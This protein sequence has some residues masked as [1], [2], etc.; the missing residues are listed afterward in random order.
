MPTPDA[1]TRREVLLTPDE[2]HGMMS[3]DPAP[4][5]LAVQSVNPC[6]GQ[7]SR[8]G[9]WIPG[10]VDAEAYTD[11]AA[12]GAPELGQRPLPEITKLQAAARR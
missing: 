7:S 5:I 8:S 3:V 10:A 4:V 1:E 11:F 2:L 9:H 6:T 12:P